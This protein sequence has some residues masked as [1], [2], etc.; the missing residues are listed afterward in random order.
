MRIG[1]NQG[2]DLFENQWESIPDLFEESPRIIDLSLE[3]VRINENQGLEL[4]W[5][6]MR[7]NSRLIWE[8]AR[9]NEN[10]GLDLFENQQESRIKNFSLIREWESMR[11][12]V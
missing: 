11:I 3:S 6:S 10:Q 2:L 5:E 12:R 8:L 4:I 1:K 7:I 9:I